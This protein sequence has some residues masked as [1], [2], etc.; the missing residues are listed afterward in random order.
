[1]KVYV[2]TLVHM[3]EVPD[4]VEMESGGS[5]R[6]LLVKV[7]EGTAAVNEIIDRGTGEITPEGLFLVELNG[8]AHNALSRGLGTELHDGDTVR[9]SLVLI[10]G[11]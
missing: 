2:K 6:D 8:V 1:M 9:L 10:G 3:P 4:V 11:G 7:F 5:L